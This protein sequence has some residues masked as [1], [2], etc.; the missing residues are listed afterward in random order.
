MRLT[1]NAGLAT[2]FVAAL[3]L[4]AYLRSAEEP[5]HDKQRATADKAFRDGNF[6]DAYK[7]FRK[8]AL[9]AKREAKE[10]SHDF[11]HALDALAR[12]GRVDETDEFREA[13]ILAHAKNWR[14]LRTAALSFV[15]REQHGYIVA[16]QFHRGHRRGGTGKFV[17]SVQRDRVRA[18]QLMQIALPLMAE[19]KDALASAEFHFDY[20]SVVRHGSGSHQAWRLQYLTDLSKL[21]DYEEGDYYGRGWGRRWRGGWDSS[22]ERG[23]PVDDQGKAVYYDTPKSW[24]DAQNDGQRWRWLLARTVE[25]SPGR[26]SEVD[27]LWA[28]FCRSQYGVQTMGWAPRAKSEDGK[29]GT[30]ALHTLKDEETIAKLAIGI[31]RF[32][33]PEKH[34]FIKLWEK[35]AARKKDRHAEQ[36]LDLLA[37]ELSDRRQYPRSAQAWRTAI[38]AFGK[39]AHDHRQH[40][41]DQIVG[42]WGLFEQGRTQPAGKKATLELR[43]RNATKA[44]FEAHALKVEQL[45][46]DVKDYI[47]AKP[48]ARGADWERM[49]IGDIGYRLVV[50]NQAKYQGDKAGDWKMD[51]KP[52]DNHVDERVSVQTPLDKP[53]AYLVTCKLEGGNTSRIVVWVADTVIVKKALENKVLYYLADA[54]TGKPVGKADLEFFGWH[55]KDLGAGNSQ[56]ETDNFARATDKDGMVMVDGTEQKQYWQWLL[57]ATKKGDGHGG[58]DRLAYL[59][60]M[61]HWFGGIHD[62]DYN[63]TRVFTIT[64]RPVYRP[65]HKVEFK[66]WVRHSRYDQA[67][68]SDFAGKPF[69]VIIRNPKDEKVY[70]KALTADDHAGLLGSWKL[71]RDATLGA[72]SIQVGHHG[73]VG[74]FRVEEYKKPEFEVKVEA[75]KEPVKLGD[76]IDATVQAKYYFGAPVTN[77]KVKIKVLRTTHTTTWYPRGKWDWFYGPGYWWYA[78]DY[79]WYPGFHEWGCCKPRPIW[80]RDWNPEQPEVVMEDEMGV[81]PDGT[82]KVTIDTAPARELHPGSDHKYAIT[83]EVTD[84]SR[85]TIVGTGDVIASRKP[86]QVFAWVDRGHYRQGDTVK[87]GFQGLTPDKKPV[88]GTGEASLVAI[89]YKEA[90]PVEKVVETWKLDTDAEGRANLQIKAAKAGQYRV[91]Y[92][93]TDDKR[94]TIEGAYVFVVRDA[95]FDGKEFRFNDLELVTDKR[96]YAAGEK[97]KLMVNT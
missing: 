72:Y 91:V 34:N 46:A 61:G 85:R 16:G 30:F 3:A 19:E 59:G 44:Q 89:S 90:A 22:D 65:D 8:L 39:G 70:E 6:N 63:A 92:K 78:Y 38:A 43:F 60:F 36:A 81:G 95:A 1:R 40:S 56:A 51:L 27:M 42:N 66:A 54:V 53:G 94:N 50:Q 5:S 21:P 31:T 86:F 20:A 26:A 83:A 10:V 77:A 2:A 12:L 57:T 55:W 79:H 4:T 73:H 13:A 96:E 87:A 28:G 18:M 35:V 37:H 15:R 49:N 69:N 58:G 14:L 75:P 47:K 48:N 93:L 84:Q 11:T 41:L 45:L 68:V 52:R 29:A 62:P 9:D 7:A 74:S 67:D 88:K 24:D 64:D 97:V 25:L 23:A 71:P 82:V 80:W 76:K 33:L 17:N 32:H